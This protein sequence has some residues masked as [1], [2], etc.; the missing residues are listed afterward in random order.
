MSDRNLLLAGEDEL[1]GAEVELAGGVK[2][3]RIIHADDG[4]RSSRLEGAALKIP[5]PPGKDILRMEGERVWR[6]SRVS[7]SHFT[8]S[9]V[10]ARPGIE[11]GTQGFSVLC[12]TN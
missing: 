3:G 7:L 9:K 4:R 1:V 2:P 11:P 10:V 6:P 12:S 5:K 8:V